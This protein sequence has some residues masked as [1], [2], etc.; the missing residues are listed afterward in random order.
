MEKECKFRQKKK[1]YIERPMGGNEVSL[2]TED[3]RCIKC[4]GIQVTV[5]K[6]VRFD[7]AMNIIISREMAKM[8]IGERSGIS[9]VANE[10][11]V[12]LVLTQ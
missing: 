10:A 2:I 3:A 5:F 7:E 6:R 1:T 8:A 12:E 4:P 9:E 11:K